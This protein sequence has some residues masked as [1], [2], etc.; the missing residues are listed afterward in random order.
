MPKT[1]DK[2][3]RQYRNNPL[4]SRFSSPVLQIYERGRA[5]NVTAN[6][7]P[8]R[9]PQNALHKLFSAGNKPRPTCTNTLRAYVI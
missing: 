1:Q 5:R 2:S 8:R 3:L 4:N 9:L 7:P 6:F